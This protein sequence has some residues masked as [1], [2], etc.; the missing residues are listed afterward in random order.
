MVHSLGR[1][2]ERIRSSDLRMRRRR[3][4]RRVIRCAHAASEVMRLSR[5]RSVEYDKRSS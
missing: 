5:S 2:C 3:C 1:R 4:M